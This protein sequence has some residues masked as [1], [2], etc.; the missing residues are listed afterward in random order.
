M[1]SC[2]KKK[3]KGPLT[4]IRV[5]K[6]SSKDGGNR[7]RGVCQDGEHTAAASCIIKAVKTVLRKPQGTGDK[8]KK[9]SFG[10]RH[11][12]RIIKK[13]EI[14]IEAVERMKTEGWC[15]DRNKNKKKRESG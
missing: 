15:G 11:P 5:M 6:S 1:C 7:V 3:K 14:E 2:V 13:M 4:E 12:D 8:W 10:G 9:C